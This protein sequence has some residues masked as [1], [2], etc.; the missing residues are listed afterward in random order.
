MTL[1]ET[2]FQWEIDALFELSWAASILQK[3]RAFDPVPENLI[4]ANNK[5]PA[6]TSK[7]RMSYF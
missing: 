2:S 5:K 1:G 7:I 3:E 4:L 6:C